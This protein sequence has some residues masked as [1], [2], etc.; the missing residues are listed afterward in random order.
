LNG[1]YVRVAD[2]YVA[3]NPARLASNVSSVELRLQRYGNIFSAWMHQSGSDWMRISA[4]AVP[5][6]SNLSVGLLVVN[7]ISTG[8]PITATFSNFKMGC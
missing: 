7:T 8:L 2:T 5:F 4:S 3:T 1:K 6:S